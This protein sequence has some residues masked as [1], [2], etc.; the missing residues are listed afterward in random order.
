MGLA[1]ARVLIERAQRED[2]GFL[3]STM[4]VLRRSPPRAIAW[5]ELMAAFTVVAWIASMAFD[6]VALATGRSQRK[7]E[8]RAAE[9]YEQSDEFRVKRALRSVIRSSIARV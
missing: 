4:L 5:P 3:D 8:E 9:D 2:A 6:L 7:A 1:G